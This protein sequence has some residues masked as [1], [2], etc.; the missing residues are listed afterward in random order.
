MGF[1][2]G[3]KKISTERGIL[4]IKGTMNAITLRIRRLSTRI[5]EEQKAAR[6]AVANGNRSMAKSHLTVVV[7]LENRRARYHQQLLTLETALLN[8]EEAKSQSDVLKAFSTANT[9]L[10]EART[11]LSPGD[12]QI[13]LDRL[14]ESFEH[15]SLA[16]E[17]L[18]EN[19][20]GVDE[21]ISAD[22]QIDR[23]LQAIEAEV[24]LEKERALPLLDTESIE[25][26]VIEQK[27]HEMEITDL[28]TRL[29]QKADEEKQRKVQN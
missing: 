1:L 20:I 16:S 17:M 24:L 3:K 26:P 14:T 22:Q 12:I 10:T 4:E 7:D 18:S 19:I 28:L 8:V 27:P 23:R 15:V 6:E 9:V 21:G 25:E 2:S 29:G 11:I 5:D 13:Q